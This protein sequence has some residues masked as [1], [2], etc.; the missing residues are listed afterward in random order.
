MGCRLKKIS[1]VK[2][3]PEQSD[4]SFFLG[5]VRAQKT[6]PMIPST[7]PELLWQKVGMDLFKWQKL[8]YLIIVDYYSAP[9]H[10]LPKKEN[11]VI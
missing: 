5:V 8:A 7:F 3:S 6:E 9:T 4:E 1:S 10:V 2:E 11:I